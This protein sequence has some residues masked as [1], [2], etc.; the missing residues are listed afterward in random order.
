MFPKCVKFGNVLSTVKDHLF[1]FGS[2]ASVAFCTLG[3]GSVDMVL[4]LLRTMLSGQVP[5]T[6]ISPSSNPFQTLHSTCVGVKGTAWAWE[7]EITAMA[8]LLNTT[9]AVF[10]RTAKKKPTTGRFTGLDR[11]IPYLIQW[12]FL[13]TCTDCILSQ[14]NTTIF[15]KPKWR[16]LFP[17]TVTESQSSSCAFPFSQTA[18]ELQSYRH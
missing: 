1:C 14:S 2:F 16:F 17:F 5:C 18:L 11:V 13:S 7:P 8:Y 12:S 9:L 10:S 6:N 3:D 15:H 4:F